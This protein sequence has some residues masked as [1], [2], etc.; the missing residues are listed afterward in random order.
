MKHNMSI[1]QRLARL[2]DSLLQ[3]LVEIARE[4]TALARQHAD[5][6]LSREERAA[7][8]QRIE[9]LRAERAAIL[10]Q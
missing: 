7:I 2:D 6:R 8:R 9:A 1:H 10:R 3:R 5:Y 4:H